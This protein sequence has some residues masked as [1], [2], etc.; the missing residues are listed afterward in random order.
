MIL[1]KETL[2]KILKEKRSPSLT[3]CEFYE[4]RLDFHSKD[5]DKAPDGRSFGDFIKS[6]PEKLLPA[7][8]AKIFRSAI[9]FPLPTVSVVKDIKATLSKVFDA[10][11]KVESLTFTDKVH[12]EDFADYREEI[13]EALLWPSA[14][15]DMYFGKVNTTL[16]I[17]LPAEQSTKLPEPKIYL[18]PIE[19]CR[20]K[21]LTENGEDMEYFI[22]QKIPTEEQRDN[23]IEEI[24][25]VYDDAYYR[26]A[27]R[28]K[29]NEDW[30]I[31]HEVAHDI[32]KCPAKHIMTTDRG[33]G[34]KL[35]PIGS[36]LGSFD[37]L[38]FR[39]IMRRCLELYAGF[40]IITTYAEFCNY[41]TPEDQ[42]PCIEGFI[43]QDNGENTPCPQCSNRSLVGPGSVKEIP[44]RVGND[45]A[46]LMPAVSL[47]VGDTAS[48]ESIQESIDID[49]AGIKE[50]ITGGGGE[51]KNDQAKNL[52]QIDSSF[53]RKQ[54]AL[55]PIARNLE[56]IQ[57]FALDVMATIRYGENF[58][59][60]SISYGNKF[61]MQTELEALEYYKLSKDAGMPNYVQEDTRIN[62][63]K[64]KY[65]NDPNVL[66]RM[67]LLDYL[68]PL[69]DYAV[70]VVDALV[71]VNDKVKYKKIHF[72]DLVKRFELE[73]GEV[74]EYRVLLDISLRVALISDILDKYVDDEY[75]EP[76]IEPEV[77]KPNK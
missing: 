63:L 35:S 19:Q 37:W 23:D 41:K 67:L 69:P 20:A 15:W 42:I 51:P 12:N 27:T 4:D 21:L 56:K 28:K 17:D 30:E 33:D 18:V 3:D 11:N 7:S 53:E 39:T 32:G 70:I 6:Y 57:K 60:S 61:F 55:S 5:T 73:H 50:R 31:I 49:I 14:I 29:M 48:L 74:T 58:I 26:V 59:H 34:V 13:K 10:Q 2:Q 71:S 16:I 22:W 75:V 72:N 36:E 52:K 47:T 64:K 77:N 76:V 62:M 25:Y 46:D 1:D 66:E 45:E 38:L 65:R 40:P 8:K 68:E 44:V 43:T 9:T 24:V 54:S